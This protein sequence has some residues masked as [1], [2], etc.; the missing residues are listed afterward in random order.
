MKKIVVICILFVIFSIKIFAQ[1][2]SVWLVGP[3]LHINFG[4]EKVRVSG[5]I[6]VSRWNTSHFPYGY[7]FG[8]EKEKQ[9]IRFYFEG[10]TGVFLAGLSLGPV[11]EYRTDESKL[12]AGMQGSVWANYVLGLD[13]RLRRI[14]HTTIKSPGVY[15]K[16]PVNKAFYDW[17][18]ESSKEDSDG[19][20]HLF[21]W[22]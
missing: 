8:V 22:D 13:F 18:D 4:G 7:D 16:V 2:T 19:N 3:M 15:F 10:Q 11:L 12:Y 14:G 6:E 21:D 1:P 17:V 20:S 9:K 5:G